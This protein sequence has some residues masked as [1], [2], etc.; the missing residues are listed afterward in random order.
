M[1]EEH[2]FYCP[3]IETGELP[4]SEAVHVLRVLR[5][6][7]GDEL[8][9]IDGVG[10]L[11][12]A[13]ITD[14]GKFKC[15]YEVMYATEQEALWCDSLHLAV[16]ATKMLERI[17]WLA[18]KATEIGF[19]RLS[20]LD[21]CFSER[22]QLK[23]ERIERIVVAAAKQSHK[24]RVPRVDD[25]QTFDSFIAEV[26]RAKHCFIAHC[27]DDAELCPNGKPFLLDALEGTT[28]DVLVLVGPEG[29]FSKTEVEQSI[30]A[31]F[32][33]VSLGHSRLRTETAGLVAVHLMNLARRK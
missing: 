33:P 25:L 29:D 28:G 9:L 5:M 27:Y 2:F 14:V 21:C 19:D 31:G 11:Y 23:R 17:E 13:K 26:P 15:R 8:S 20:F 22:K 16:A 24:A 1:K 10:G 6:K 4:P 7:E 30:H 32:V 3:N 12:R 18:E